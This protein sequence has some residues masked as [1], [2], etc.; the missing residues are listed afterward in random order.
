MQ[1]TTNKETLYIDLQEYYDGNERK[2]HKRIEI[3]STDIDDIM[4]EIQEI[5][6]AHIDDWE[7]PQSIKKWI[8]DNRDIDNWRTPDRDIG[9]FINDN[10]TL[11]ITNTF[12]VVDDPTE[13][14]TMETSGTYYD[15]WHEIEV[16]NDNQRND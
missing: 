5:M 14:N 10:L 4:D 11:G 1:T 3:K 12:D 15:L 2:H 9:Y 13:W 8:L 7:S 6:P 16:P